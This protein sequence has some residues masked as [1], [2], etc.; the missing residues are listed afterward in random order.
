MLI[1]A[2]FGFGCEF[3]RPFLLLNFCFVIFHISYNLHLEIDN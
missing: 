1:S 2:K 3:G